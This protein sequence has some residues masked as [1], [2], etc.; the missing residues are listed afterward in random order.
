MPALSPAVQEGAPTLP[1]PKFW[2]PQRQRRATAPMPKDSLT[3]RASA[4]PGCC[5]APPWGPLRCRLQGEERISRAWMQ[6]PAAVSRREPGCPVHG[7]G[8]QAGRRAGRR[9][10]RAVHSP[11]RHTT[12][13]VAEE[14]PGASTTTVSSSCKEAGRQAGGA[15]TCQSA[16]WL[17]HRQPPQHHPMRVT[18]WC[19]NHCITTATSICCPALHS[20]KNSPQSPPAGCPLRAPSPAPAAPLA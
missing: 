15:G 19:R 13:W 20:C 4:Q 16:L 12:R 5:P 6:M 18:A 7:A 10:G 14:P 2:L 1:P 8:G 9:A 3:L 11:L 17:L